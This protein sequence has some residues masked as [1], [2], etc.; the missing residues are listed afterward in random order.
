MTL[1]IIYATDKAGSL[2]TRLD[3]Y[4]AHRAYVEAQDELKQVAV[5]F[6]GPLQTDDGG[7][8]IG[9]MIMLDAPNRDNVMAFVAEN[10]FYK[11]GIWET[12]NVTRFHCRHATPRTLKSFLP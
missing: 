7:T 1:Y 12:V 3:H 9:S 6:S 11:A 2:Q 10:P 4:A 8:M 5:V